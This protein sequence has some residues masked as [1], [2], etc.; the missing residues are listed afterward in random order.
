M[1]PTVSPAPGPDSDELIYRHNPALQDEAVDANGELRPHWS[2]LLDSLKELGSASFDER[3]TKALRILRDDGATYNIYSDSST[4]SHTWNMDL[5]PYVI[6]SDEWGRIEAGLLERAELF[7]LLLRD[8]YGNRDLIRSGVIPPDAL[9]C[10]RGFLRACNGI[11][12]PGDHDLILHSV[13]LVRGADGQMMAIGDRAQSPSGAGYSLENRNVMSRVF[14]S[15]FRDSHVHRLAA[16]F[17]RLR[18]KLNS[19]S[20]NTS[21]PR[22]AVMTPGAHNET[23]FE[24]AYLANYLGFHLVQSDDLVVRNG[25]LWMKSLDG[26][27]R[28]DVLLR[29]V[30]DWFCDPVEL[31]G[32]SRLGVANLL[33]VVR[34][35]NV[36][37]AN[38]L[39]SGVLEN[40]V[41]LRFLPGIAKHLLGRE[42]RLPSVETRW[43]GLDEDRAY[44]LDHLHELVIKPVYRNLDNRSLYGPE[45]GQ[46]ETRILKARIEADPTQYVAQPVMEASHV[47]SFVDGVLKPRP[48]ILRS[49]AV[50]TDTSYTVMPGGLTR[51]GHGER[52]FMISSQTGSKSKDTWVIASEPERLA[53]DEQLDEPVS[54]EADLISLPS[55]VVENLFWMGRYAERAEAALRILRTAFM[56]L[57]GEERISDITQHQLLHAVSMITATPSRSTDD[58]T[59]EEALR[60]I[61]ENGS[62]LRSISGNLNAMLYCADET[63]ELLSSDTYRVINDI[64]DALNMLGISFS[65]SLASAPEEALDPLVTALMALSGL[66]QESMIRGFGWRFMDMGRRLERGYQIAIAIDSLIV[67]VLSESDQS[68]LCEALLLSLEALISYRRRYRARVGIQ[69]SLDLVMMDPTNPRS[70]MYQVEQ[71]RQHIR[72][73]PKT[74]TQMHELAADERRILECETLLKLSSLAELSKADGFQRSHLDEQMKKIASQ[75]SGLSEMI[76]DKYFDHREASQQLVNSTWESI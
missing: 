7:N 14:P 22:V 25:F 13:D 68:K 70:L 38:P 23:Y 55:R 29:R 11:H 20:P 30:D 61:I 56:M 69:T 15:L 41:F 43:C 27:S 73:L 44:V 4:P 59:A 18:S 62:V 39:G 60:G 64:R 10:H 47:P 45:L 40:P 26:L 50:A 51:I 24:H 67:P 1:S 58:Q 65:G 19:L 32:D 28:V 37:V 9:F 31:R 5:V 52:S 54:R 2:Y 34:A 46:E 66:T 48:V 49:F 53:H 57:N 21:T 3:Q 17:Q 71:L 35:G 63:K 6:G 33:E 74:P 16:F 42:L 12:L 75:L 72:A 76:T 36:V 8:L